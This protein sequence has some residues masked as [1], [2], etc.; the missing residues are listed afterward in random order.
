MSWANAQADHKI[1]WSEGGRTVEENCQI[2]CKKCNQ[3]KSNKIWEEYLN[4]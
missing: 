4:E 2:L 1:P 3:H